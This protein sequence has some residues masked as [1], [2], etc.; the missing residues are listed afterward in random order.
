MAGI[1]SS[2]NI[3]KL[4]ANASLSLDKRWDA[5]EERF[6]SPVLNVSLELRS[7]VSSIFLTNTDTEKLAS[8]VA[9]NFSHS[10]SP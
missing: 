6:E 9:L 7:D 4:L 1:L 3:Q 10:V 2:P 5:L 8:N